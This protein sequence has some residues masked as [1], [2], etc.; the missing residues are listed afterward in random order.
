MEEP[1]AEDIG[2][3]QRFRNVLLELAHQ[4][5]IDDDLGLVCGPGVVLM[6]FEKVDLLLQFQRVGPVVVTLADGNVFTLAGQQGSREVRH[7]AQVSIA[8]QQAHT[9]IALREFLANGRG[10]V[11]AAVVTNDQFEREINVL[12]KNA[13]NGLFYIESMIEGNHANTDFRDCIVIFHRYL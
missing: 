6:A 11:R 13:F 7:H 10:V 3:N 9:G 12:R 2:R 5:V 8:R 1:A 4:R